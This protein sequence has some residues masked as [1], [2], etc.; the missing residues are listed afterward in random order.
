MATLTPVAD[1]FIRIHEQVSALLAI[2]DRPFATVLREKG[3]RKFQEFGIPT[4]KDEEFKYTPLRALKETSY[5][6][7]FGANVDRSDLEKLP[8][9]HID[10]HVLGFV[11]GQFAPEISNL[12]EL[13]D[14]VFVG[15]L[16]ELPEELEALVASKMG[17]IATYEGKLGS[18]NDD[19]FVALNSA[20]LTDCAV[21]YVPEGIEASKPIHLL[22]LNKAGDQAAFVT[23]RVLVVME[24]N[25]SAQLFESYAT[26]AGS[27]FTVPVVE[28]EIAED[29]KLEHLRYQD[30]SL[31]SIHVSNTFVNQATASV[32]TSNNVNFGGIVAR[33]DINV[34]VGGE[35]CETWLNGANVGAGEQVIDNHTRI[36]H[37]LPNCQSF[38][39]YK[40]I[41]K[42]KAEGVFNGKIFVYEDAQKTDAK[43]TNQ[44][45]LLSPTATM[46][47]KPQLEI[48]ADDVK[49]THGATIG[50]LRED[51]LFYLRAR[52]VEKSKAEGLL[53]FAFAGEVVEKVTNDEARE[54]LVEAL[55]AKLA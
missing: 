12:S 48:F 50:Q 3:L 5:E 25:A 23:P 45:M 41:L 4:H 22:F 40:S 8:L 11:N 52:G 39:I 20:F 36:D 19:R 31:T 26:L 34:W 21:V 27:S 14:G 9:S 24:A 15:P 44:A 42:D 10:S 13:G 28:I 33:N 18:T 30:E 2:E 49:C 1:P 29:A 17:T 46:N 43:Q 51:A 37:A 54:A 7:G 38:E 53:V 55:F 47:T 6:F 32:Y 35:N 16:S